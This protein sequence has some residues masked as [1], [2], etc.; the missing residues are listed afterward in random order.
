MRTTLPYKFLFLILALFGI[1]FTSLHSALATRASLPDLAWPQITL[2]P[3]QSGFNSPVHI[4]HAGDSSQ[5]LFVVEQ[6]GTIRIIKNNV[7]LSTPF[8]D[9]QERVYY[10]GF[11]E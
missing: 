8:L 7:V 3:Y 5:R 4:T 10:P 2:T 11:R 9:I 6:S 1:T